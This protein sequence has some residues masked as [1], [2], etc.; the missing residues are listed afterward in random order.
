MYFPPDRVLDGLVDFVNY[1]RS[2]FRLV[3]R[4]DRTVVSVLGQRGLYCTLTDTER[5]K[6]RRSSVLSSV[7]SCLVFTLFFKQIFVQTNDNSLLTDA[8][9]LNKYIYILK[10]RPFA[11]E[12]YKRLL[13]RMDFSWK[14]TRLRHPC[15]VRIKNNGVLKTR[16]NP[17][18]KQ[19]RRV[20]V[21]ERQISETLVACALYTN[22]ANSLSDGSSR[23]LRHVFRRVSVVRMREKGRISVADLKRSL[24]GHGKRIIECKRTRLD[25][26]VTKL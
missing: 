13:F 4:R 14:R 10:N 20:C 25:S 11:I 6:F 24:G 9:K 1:R 12:K 8:D 17:M 16:K 19:K 22:T 23:C 7:G 26:A 5:L 15:R 2:V 18:K 21:Q 3:G